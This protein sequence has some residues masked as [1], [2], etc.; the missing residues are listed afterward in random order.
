MLL[1]CIC[2]ERQCMDKR[3]HRK[4]NFAP[5]KRT[6]SRHR[7]FLTSRTTRAESC[8]M[9]SDRCARVLDAKMSF[10]RSTCSH[11]RSSVLSS[12]TLFASSGTSIFILQTE[13]GTAK[14]NIYK[15]VYI[16]QQVDR[17]YLQQKKTGS[18]SLK[19]SSPH[20]TCLIGLYY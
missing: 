10:V 4:Q 9:S 18:S 17:Y 13:L 3:F 15:S 5:R 11:H 6:L 7:K 14:K 16:M 19:Y 2:D 8:R 20:H 1:S 12:E